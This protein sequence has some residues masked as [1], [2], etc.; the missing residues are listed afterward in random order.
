MKL[1]VQNLN[2]S[3]NTVQTMSSLEIAELTGKE[4]RN[5]LRDIRTMLEELYSEKGMLSFELQGLDCHACS[6]G[7]LYKYYHCG[8]TL[9][10]Q[11]FQLHQ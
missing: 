3:N 11:G 5:V 2:L 7:T 4:H 8:R 6:A 10:L 1:Q 9:A